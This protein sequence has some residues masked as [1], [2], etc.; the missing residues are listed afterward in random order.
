MENNWTNTISQ[1]IENEVLKLYKR[2]V[3]YYQVDR[4]KRMAERIEKFGESCQYC[5]DLKK[6]IEDI[7][8]N[9]STY[10]DD[11]P[12]GRRRL[13]KMDENIKKHLK[14]EHEIYPVY[15]NVSLYSF[16]GMTIGAA[17]GVPVHFIIPE[18]R[19]IISIGIPWVI[20]LLIGYF[21]G[22]KKDWKIRRSYRLL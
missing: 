21:I 6:D 7:S 22:N 13:E 20:G 18:T 3:K 10:I 17:A 14:V 1:N 2:D 16:L 5:R 19:L 12:T 11:I 9:L 8:I 15:Y 4:F